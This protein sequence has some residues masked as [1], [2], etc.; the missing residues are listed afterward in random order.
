MEMKYRYFTIILLTISVL[1][2]MGAAQANIKCWINK[3][4]VRECG[5]AVPQEYSQQRIEVINSKGIVVR[6]IPAKEELDAIRRQEKLRKAEERK[7]AAARRKDLI[8]LQT[9]T[10]ERDLLLSRK[11]NLQAVDGIINITNS[12]TNTLKEN[13]TILEK[14][15]A[16]YE[17]NG[18]QIPDELLSDMANLKNQIKDN[19]EFIAKKKLAKQATEAKFDADLKR[20]RELKGITPPQKH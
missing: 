3:D 11:H 8:L 15:A 13:L 20:F 1:L 18:E 4:G 17:R 10:T 9:Y 5:Q 19:E 16:D 14:S 2:P 6:V 12:N 7:K